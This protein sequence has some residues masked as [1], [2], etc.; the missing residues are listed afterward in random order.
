M[1]VLDGV[2]HPHMVLKNATYLNTYLHQ[3]LVANIWIYYDR[4]VYVGDKLPENSCGYEEIDCQGQYLVP[5]YIEPHAHPDQLYNPLTLAKHAG[6]FGT[7]ALISDNL[8]IFLELTTQVAFE[9]LNEFKEIPSTMYWWCRFDAQTEFP[10]NDEIFNTEDVTSWLQHE[11]VLQGGELTGWPKLLNGDDQMLSWL[12][13]TKRLHKK[14]E[15][16]LPGA[17]ER[18]LAKLMLMAQIVIM[19]L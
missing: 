14:V 3:W 2:I 1:K 13:E 8:G 16:H 11:S 5:G 17:S 9:L 18:T 19:K 7:T 6:Q 4:I 12:Q 10:N 15:G